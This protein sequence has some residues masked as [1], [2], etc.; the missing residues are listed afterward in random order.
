[1]GFDAP[2]RPR[3][4]FMLP[5]LISEIKSSI[6]REFKQHTGGFAGSWKLS[7]LRLTA[8]KKGIHI[9]SDH[10]AA[11][12]QNDGG[13]VPE[14]VAK[15]AKAMHWMSGGEHVFAKRAK[16]FT[17]PGKKY[18]QKALERWTGTGINVEWAD[19]GKR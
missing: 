3:W 4:K 5:E 8:D 19:K 18:V 2:L 17:L 14:R 11:K 15:R 6:R 9:N 10:P 7:N 16:G 13:D 12:I 1:M